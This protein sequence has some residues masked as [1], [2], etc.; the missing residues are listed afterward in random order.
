[1]R[2]HLKVQEDIGAS[3]SKASPITAPPMAR[4]IESFMIQPRPL[5]S[6]ITTPTIANHRLIPV[7]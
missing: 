1:M 5:G 2:Y 7:N 6:R 4:V 3:G